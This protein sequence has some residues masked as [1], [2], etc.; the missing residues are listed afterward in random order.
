MYTCVSYNMYTPKHIYIY[1]YMHMH[2][3]AYKSICISISVHIQTD[4][5]LHACIHTYIRVHKHPMYTNSHAYIHSCHQLS[6]SYARSPCV[7]V[8]L[9]VGH[10]CLG[11]WEADPAARQHLAVD[12]EPGRV[13]QPRTIRL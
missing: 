8:D 13:D 9:L 6:R 7:L 3:C 12:A 10:G 5:H 11:P 1:T 2:M 4:I